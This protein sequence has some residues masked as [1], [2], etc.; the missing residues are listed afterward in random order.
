MK[1]KIN[2]TRSTV[3]FVV[4][5]FA[6]LVLIARLF[7]LQIIDGKEYADNFQLK[8]KKTL[9]LKSTR[10]NIYDRNKTL[11]AGNKLAYAATVE[12]NM[13]YESKRVRQLTLN[14]MAFQLQKVFEKNHEQLSQELK[15]AVNAQDEFEFTTEGTSLLRF[16]ADVFGKADIKEM[17]P[18]ESEMTAEGMITYLSKKFSLYEEGKEPYSFTEL[19]PY[20]LK[21]SY[22]KAEILGILGIRYSLS[23]NTY[24]KY[25]PVTVAKNI[26]VETAAYIFE[27]RDSLPGVDVQEE[28]LRVYEGGDAFSH[29]LGYTGKI[30]TD[31][32]ELLKKSKDTYSLQSL[33]GKSG[34]E[35]YMEETLQGIDGKKEVYVNNVGRVLQEE[36]TQIDPTSGQDVDLSIDKNLQ[37]SVYKMLEQR[38]AGI[39]LSNIINTKVFDKASIKDASEIKIPIYDVYI[40]LVKNGVIDLKRMISEDATE[41]EQNINGRLD[42]RKREVLDAIREELVGESSVYKDLPEEVQEYESFIVEE[43]G[44]LDKSMIAPSDE[45]YLLWNEE[46]G[47]SIKDF[48]MHA[49]Q[50]NWINKERISLK[51]G[52]LTSEE[53]YLNVVEDIMNQISQDNAFDK[54]IVKYMLLNDR[55]SGTEVCRL[56]YDQEV[57]A[58]ED[59]EYQAL[60]EGRMPPYEFMLEK[61]RKL[62]ITPAQ[63]ALDPYSGS[64]VVV[65]AK[66]GKVLACVTYPGYDNNRLANVMDSQYY[67]QL[68]DDLSAPF[69]NR[70]TQQLTAPGSTFKPITI[71]AG[72]QEDVIDSGTSI[73]CDGIFDKVAPPLK[74]WNKAGHGK[75]ADAAS[76]LEHSCNDYLCDI[77]YRFGQ[78]DTKEFND[79]QA[80]ECLQRYA[81]L[82][83][84]DK[85]SG[86]EIPESEPKVTDYAAIPSAIGQ[87]THNYSTVQLA[88]YTNTL[89]SRGMSFQLSLLGEELAASQIENKVEL[90]NQVWDTVGMGMRQFI[91]SNDMFQE[92]NLPV[93]GKSGTAQEADDR[94]DHALFIGYAPAKD[95]EISIAVRIANGYASG[96][97][98]ALGKDVFSYYFNLKNEDELLS[99]NASEANNIRTD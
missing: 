37:I 75:I 51:T 9:V 53:V 32:L 67:H 18:E 66:T 33:V 70:A 44:L 63:L 98:V 47:I 55:I 34:I 64:A 57:L 3:L 83:H 72:M 43:L 15:I 36:K 17:A 80:L 41:L 25:L 86:V 84:L 11:L 35:Q 42:G 76:A 30:S 71:I 61:L 58:K 16:K 54:E 40:A 13:E 28:W 5:C 65:E 20:Q 87:G 60:Q 68:Y 23:L 21:E 10:G 59:T 81:K 91:E 39:L 8:T 46:G 96:N 94:P 45:I 78:T 48:L 14:G 49:I 26:S 82:F 62:E 12:D 52:Y 4:F 50:N 2:I 6:F 29:I 77:S 73:I 99:G 88:R 93:A 22:K 31:E 89:A 7:K 95:P 97:A 79:S 90:P 27:N 85:K 38:I 69:Y 1:K 19:E 56:L 24:Q 92:F 74:C